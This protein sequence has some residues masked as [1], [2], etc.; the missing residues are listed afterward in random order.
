MV[1][2]RL[3]NE[4]VYNCVPR[5]ALSAAW[6]LEYIYVNPNRSIY[7]KS[8]ETNFCIAR[9]SASKMLV[10]LEKMNLIERQR[11]SHDAR[12]KKLV[13]TETGKVA[14]EEIHAESEK[15]END[16]LNSV[17]PSEARYFLALLEKLS[18]SQT[19]Y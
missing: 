6:I 17:A 15:I 9:S 19:Q 16:I 8:I 5:G 14:A 11:V 4:R 2:E 13:L 1:D 7:Q 18:L 10:M 12:L 3:S